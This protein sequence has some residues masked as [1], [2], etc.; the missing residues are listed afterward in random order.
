MRG[1]KKI[2]K[3]VIIN[4]NK[5]YKSICKYVNGKKCHSNKKTLSQLEITSI[6]KG[7]FIPGLFNDII[8][9]DM[10]RYKTRKNRK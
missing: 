8:N 10:N 5:G 9:P 3:K 6:Q 7:R 1:G 4:K 2:T